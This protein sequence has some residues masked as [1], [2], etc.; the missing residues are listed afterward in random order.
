MGTGGILMTYTRV[1]APVGN[2]EDFT[3]TNLKQQ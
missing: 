2:Y 3:E 1:V